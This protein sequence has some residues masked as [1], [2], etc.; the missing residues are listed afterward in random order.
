MEAGRYC[1]AIFLDVSQAFDKVWHRGLLYKIKKRFPTDLYIIIK[2]YLLHRTFR[3]KYDE[4]IIQLKEINSGVPQDSVLG[5]VLYLFYTV[6]LPVALSSTTAI[7][8][9]NIAILAVHNSHIEVSS[10][11]GN[12]LHRKV[13]IT[14][15]NSLKME[16]QGQR[17]KIN[18][19]DIYYPKRDVSTSNA[20]W[21]ENL[22]SWTKPN[23]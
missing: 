20:E 10:R 3:V 23:I 16:N 11:L 17:K 13:S 15:R 12:L 1:S 8:A 18:T 7:Y 21:L 4:D 19:G 5:S 9:D 22:I 14:F 2:S 6:D